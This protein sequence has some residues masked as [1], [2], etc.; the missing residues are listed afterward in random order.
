MGIENGEVEEGRGEKEKKT[1]YGLEMLRQATS[2]EAR[3]RNQRALS[4]RGDYTR[5]MRRERDENKKVAK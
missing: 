3:R 2:E 5:K 4:R 1:K